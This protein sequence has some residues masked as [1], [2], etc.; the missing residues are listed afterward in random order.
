MQIT[1]NPFVRRQTADSSF[2]HYAGDIDLLPNLISDKVGNWRPGYRDGV[3]LVSVDPEDFFSGVITLEEG[4]KLTGFFEARRD[5]EAP[6]KEIRADSPLERKIAAQ[7]VEIVLYRS[8]VLAEGGD[9][10]LEPSTENWEIIS[11]NASPTEGEMPI[12]PMTLMHN[13]FGS[14]GGTDTNMTD[15]EFVQALREGFK[16]WANKALC[17]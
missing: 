15:A 17:A 2:S 13:H 10:S 5:G 3:V 16:F 8:D 12:A 1:V 9:N 14:D 4:A 7:S 6:R 11:I